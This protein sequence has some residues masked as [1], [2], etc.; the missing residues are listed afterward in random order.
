MTKC[1]GQEGLPGRDISIV[2]CV[3]VWAHRLVIAISGCIGNSAMPLLRKRSSKICWENQSHTESPYKTAHI[4]SKGCANEVSR[5]QISGWIGLFFN[6]LLIFTV[7]PGILIWDEYLFAPGVVFLQQKCFP[8]LR[9]S[10]LNYIAVCVNLFSSFLLPFPLSLGWLVTAYTTVL[11]KAWWGTRRRWRSPTTSMRTTIPWRGSPW[12][13]AWPCAQWL[14]FW[15]GEE[16]SCSSWSWQL[17]HRFCS[18][19]FSTVSWRQE[20]F[21][22]TQ[23]S[24]VWVQR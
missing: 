2:L 1:H 10:T 6:S 15:G 21:R 13:P 22:T 19:A 5:L 4:L 3:A 7:T 14:G 17:W 11:Q 9:V 8:H 16:D 12:H 24:W 23:G 20:L 18:W